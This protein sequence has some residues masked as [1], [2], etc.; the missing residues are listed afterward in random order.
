MDDRA[1]LQEL[2]LTVLYPRRA[3]ITLHI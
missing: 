2:N 3:P 1:I